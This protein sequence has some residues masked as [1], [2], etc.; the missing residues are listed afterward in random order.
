[1]KIG[2][3]DD[4][5]FMRMVLRQIF[6]TVDDIEVLWEAPDGDVAIKRN[7]EVEVD[8]IIAD[9]EMPNC[10]GL[11][12]LTKLK[13]SKV[14]TECLIIS[15]F[16]AYGGDK[17]LEAMRIGAAGFLPKSE[18]GVTVNLEEFRNRLIAWVH[19]FSKEH[20][21]KAPFEN[22]RGLSAGVDTAVL[23]SNADSLVIIGSAGSLGPLEEILNVCVDLER[24]L[25]VAVHMPTG[26]ETKLISRIFRAI[27]LENRP[28]IHFDHVQCSGSA[29]TI[30]RGGALSK[31][32]KVDNEIRINYRSPNSQNDIFAPNIDD[33][34]D[35]CLAIGFLCDVVV[36]SGLCRDGVAGAL[37]HRMNGGLLLVQDTGTAV[38]KS[39][40]AAAAKSGEATVVATS[41]AIAAILARTYK[42]TK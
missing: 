35:S 18:I 5:A 25:I 2:L 30:L 29:V 28:N 20:L 32:V 6:S 23:K 9:M 15:S 10:D 27:P 22:A 33:F 39:M 14:A 21:N 12:L 26:L 3:V 19:L 36:L 7:A 16:H 11:H 34:L 13:S 17:I 37:R 31:L 4:S 1:M 38:A 41:Q 8:L 24:P 42:R 40:P